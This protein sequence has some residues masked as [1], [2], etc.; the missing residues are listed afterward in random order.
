MMKL[1][2]LVAALILAASIPGCGFWSLTNVPSVDHSELAAPTL[3]GWPRVGLFWD[4]IF[5][6]P[7]FTRPSIAIPVQSITRD[8]LD[9]AVD[10]SLWR[11]GHSTILLKSHGYY[12][13]FDPM[14]SERASPFSWVGPKRF[15]APPINI[16]DL[17][18]IEAVIISH[19]HYDHLD[20][21]S[22]YAL[23]KKTR[24]FVTPSGVGDL[25]IEWGISPEKVSQ[26][27]W[28][29]KVNVSGVTFVSTPA[30]HFSGRGFF[31]KNRR[32]WTSWVILADKYRLFFSGDSGYFDGFKTIGTKYGPFDITMLETGA[33]DSR[34]P[35]VHMR[36][37]QT[38]QAAIDLKGHWLLPIH[39]GTFDLAFHRWSEPLERVSNIAKEANVQLLTP[40][41]GHQVELGNIKAQS[42]W[43][44]AN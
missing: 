35:F 5:N 37:E 9:K 1:L 20:K 7:S 38:V 44:E 10:G 19:D 30:Q 40:I 42:P 34:W 21:Q 43:W 11:L 8:D 3:S 41:I 29:S 32:L 2:R 14:F 13:L 15:H 4:A 18:E 33:Y 23:D 27:E 24:N 26:L 36:P 6:K 31:D 25:I 39:N 22:I 28:W 17:P 16:D 12:W